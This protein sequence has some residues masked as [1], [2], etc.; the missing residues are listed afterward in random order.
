MRSSWLALAMKS[1]RMRSMRRA[2]LWSLKTSTNSPVPRPIADAGDPVDA[3][4]RH[5]LDIVDDVAMRRARTARA[6]S[7]PASR[8][9]GTSASSDMPG[10]SA[11]KA[12]RAASLAWT[13]VPA[14]VEDDQ[15]IGDGGGKA[16]RRQA[17]AAC[18]RRSAAARSAWCAASGAAPARSRAERQTAT[19]RTTWRDSRRSHGRPGRRRCRLPA[20]SD[21]SASR[22]ATSRA[23][24]RASSAPMS[25]ISASGSL[26]PCSLTTSRWTGHRRTQ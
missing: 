19:P 4:D 25:A 10:A 16:L 7:P 15:R 8:A 20:A 9:R 13:T 11:P 1:A 3:L 14:R 21:C 5:A 18:R 12:A 17:V 26:A 6:R 24:R 22:P 2:S 23:M